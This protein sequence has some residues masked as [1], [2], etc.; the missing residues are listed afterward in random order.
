MSE[1]RNHRL[2]DMDV[3][4]AVLAAE[5]DDEL[6]DDSDCD[7]SWE[8]SNEEVV[9]LESEEELSGGEVSS[10]LSG[11]N[12]SLPSVDTKRSPCDPSPSTSMVTS[13]P[14]V[15]SKPK[16]S[17][18]RAASDRL[19]WHRDIDNSH[20]N[21][22]QIFTGQHRVNLGG[23]KSEP[24]NLFRHF[25]S[26]SLLDDI[27]YHTNLYASQQDISNQLNLTRGELMVFL[28]INIVMTYIRYPR[29]RM[30]WSSESGVRCDIVADKMP[31]NRFERI[32]RYLHFSDNSTHDSSDTDKLWKLR[33][34][35][36]VL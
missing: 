24:I 10:Q 28:G 25:F 4:E 26:E 27:V 36:D 8:P 5:S 6:I 16:A 17:N 1:A 9:E 15:T 20:S 30:Y 2:R 35:L 33:P 13:T 3:V 31:V 32:R 18:S 23:E 29:V 22:P 11:I 14:K 7:P 34:V 12:L 21:N 19:G